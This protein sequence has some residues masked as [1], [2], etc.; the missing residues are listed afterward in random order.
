MA[1]M[2]ELCQQNQT[3]QA[4]VQD[5]TRNHRRDAYP[6]Q[7]APEF[8][9][10]SEAI[11][12]VEIP[13]SLRT[14]VLDSYDGTTDPREHL[15][16]FNTK[17]LIN[18]ATEQLKCKLFPGTLKNGA[19]TWF[20]SLP[21]RSIVTF[22]DFSQHFLS[23]FSAKQANQITSASLFNIRQKSGESLKNYLFRFTNVFMQARN[24]DPTICTE[25]FENGLSAGPFNEDLPIRH[26]Q[27][28]DEIR[29]RAAPFIIQEESNRLK[30]DRDKE[31]R[32]R[33]QTNQP[34]RTDPFTDRGNL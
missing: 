21:P 30:A 22:S 9:P 27:S 14:L 17:M 32:A 12:V 23:Q 16:I 25:A 15:A 5:L 31:E 20:S 8:Q 29:K 1:G 19:L 2:E 18:G 34:R 7:T 13:E 33:H 24:K 4:Q 6:L 28:L 3:L 11:A 10:F 26:A